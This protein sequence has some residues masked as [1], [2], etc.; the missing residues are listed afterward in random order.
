MH[1]CAIER[2]GASRFDW[3]LL[4]GIM[5]YV[6]E[7]N[8]TWYSW[9]TLDQIPC[10]LTHTKFLDRLLY[11]FSIFEGLFNDDNIEKY[12]DLV[13]TNLIDKNCYCIAYFFTEELYSR[14]IS[15]T[16]VKIDINVCIPNIISGSQRTQLM[17]QRVLYFI[18]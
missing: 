6:Y 18:L 9:E 13:I 8:S 2:I 15:S 3:S 7:L 10:A 11:I 17:S 16:I 4:S 14:I 12:F 1:I 5:C